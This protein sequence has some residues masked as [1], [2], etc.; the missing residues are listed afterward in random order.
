MAPS[1][2]ATPCRNEETGNNSSVQFVPVCDTTPPE[3]E[4][5]VDPGHSVRRGQDVALAVGQV[6]ADHNK[7]SVCAAN[8][9]QVCRNAGTLRQ[10]VCSIG[11]SD[12]GPVFA[13]RDKKTIA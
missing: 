3:T 13:D 5:V 11:G 8:G 6:R 7:S 2:L 9:N 4:V 1:P 12:D 10:P